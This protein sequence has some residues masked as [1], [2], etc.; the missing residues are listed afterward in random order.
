MRDYLGYRNK[1]IIIEK[2]GNLTTEINKANKEIIIIETFFYDI[3][4]ILYD[5]SII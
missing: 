1:T 3:I 2:A 5:D 4:N